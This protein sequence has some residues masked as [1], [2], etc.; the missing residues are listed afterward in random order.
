MNP[1]HGEIS[2]SMRNRGIEI[3]IT[4]PVIVCVC[5]VCLVCVSV[6]VFTVFPR[7]G[8]AA[9][10]FLTSHELWRQFKGGNSRVA[11]TRGWRQ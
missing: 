7:S 5:C 10:I 11:S 9:T 3:F 1:V 4:P 6:Y 8:A 2:R